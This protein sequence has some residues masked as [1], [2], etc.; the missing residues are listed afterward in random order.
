MMTREEAFR[1][2]NFAN[3]K[4]VAQ[5]HERSEWYRQLLRQAWPCGGVVRY[6][7]DLALQ[8]RGVDVTLELNDGRSIILD[9]KFREKVWDDFALEFMSDQE[10]NKAGWIERD[11]ICDFIGYWFVP[12][13]HGFLLPWAQLKP[14]WNKNR[15][16]WK[17]GYGVVPVRN[18]D[19]G[20]TW[21]TLV[22]FVDRRKLEEAKVEIIR[23]PME[24]SD[25]AK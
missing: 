1:S 15:E 9:N 2:H 18:R 20:R 25:G 19:G 21:T 11:L 12:T 22:V 5:G 6:N 7:D 16:T 23:V 4:H 10:N 3:S 14:A 8:E 17:T 13:Q 24:N